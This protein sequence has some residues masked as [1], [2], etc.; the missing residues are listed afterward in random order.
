VGLAA[1]IN[2]SE[3]II[4]FGDYSDN[5]CSDNAGCT[6]W[7]DDN[8]S[9]QWIAGTRWIITSGTSLAGAKA[10]ESRPSSG[11]VQVQVLRSF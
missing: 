10:G 6:N 11:T 7:E 3:N 2:L 5:D 1:H 4:L 8:F 9:S